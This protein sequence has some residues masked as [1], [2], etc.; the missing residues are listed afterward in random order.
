MTEFVYNNSENASTEII[1][2]FMTYDR[3]SQI[4]DEVNHSQIKVSMTWVCA[5]TVIDLCFYLKRSWDVIA[6][7]ASQNYDKKWKNITF[8]ISNW[9]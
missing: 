7:T 5:D 6:K 1:P 3:H 8:K 4:D 2:F 9:V